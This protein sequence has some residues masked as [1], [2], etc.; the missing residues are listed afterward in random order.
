MPSSVS[1][2]LDSGSEREQLTLDL[3]GKSNPEDNVL[4]R[5]TLKEM[6]AYVEGRKAGS[7]VR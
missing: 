6:A 7:A 5:L 4:P 3:A 1:L 2:A